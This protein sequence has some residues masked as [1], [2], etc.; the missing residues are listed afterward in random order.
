[1][2]T[3]NSVPSGLLSTVD[4]TGTLNIQTNSV[5]ALAIDTNQNATMNY[6]SA[7]NTF[8]FKNRIINGAMVI[9]Q[10]RGGASFTPSNGGQQ[11]SVDRWSVQFDTAVTSVQR[12]SD[13]PTGFQNSLKV[14]ITT[15]TT[16]G[17]AFICQNIEGYN[18][19]D[20]MYGSASAKTVTASFWVKS[21][22]PGTYTFAM[23][24]NAGT[25]CYTATYVINTANTWQYVTVTIPGETTGTN[26][27]YT[28]GYGVTA[29]FDLGCASVGT[30]NTWNTTDTKRASGAVQLA[31]T[32]G[33]TF[34]VTGV[35]LEKGSIATP[36]DYRDYGR[37]LILCQRYYQ[38]YG[39]VSYAGIASGMLTNTNTKASIANIFNTVMRAA[40]ALNFSSLIV[41]DRVAY[42]TTVSGVNFAI[43]SPNGYFVQ[44]NLSS[45]GGGA[46]QP[47][48]LCVQ[49]TTTGTL[50]FNA[51][52]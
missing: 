44:F 48:L 25:R 26:W 40:P 41:T 36:F 13:A 2:T 17:Q 35:Q 4:T 30:P 9:D 47:T 46:N 39:G 7:Q 31:L 38:V 5:N 49:S 1:M 10:R 24:D 16:S 14:T 50:T 3:L 32:V 20:I 18:W 19:A 43:M 33:A 23:E 22:I 45:T 28:T 15:A 37:E 12:V 11:Y 52:L 6:V 29:I 8:G 42:D 27:Q 34:Q 51:E 21:S